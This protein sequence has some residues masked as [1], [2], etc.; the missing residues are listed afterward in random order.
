MFGLIRVAVAFTLI[1][2]ATQASALPNHGA[3]HP[4][5]GQHQEL[6]GPAPVAKPA[7]LIQA[8]KELENA[9]IALQIDQKALEQLREE[10]ARLRQ[11]AILKSGSWIEPNEW[12]KKKQLLKQSIEMKQRAVTNAKHRLTRA[13][14]EAHSTSEGSWVRHHRPSWFRS[15]WQW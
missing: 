1:S 2:L 5:D 8:Q 3:H 15:W 6:H 12:W 7:F 10:E 11:A 4:Q 13:E 14:N 9:E